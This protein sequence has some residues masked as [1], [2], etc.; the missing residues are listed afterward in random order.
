M[1]W[2]HEMIMEH[3]KYFKGIRRILDFC[4]VTCL[5]ILE[6]WNLCRGLREIIRNAILDL[7]I[8]VGNFKRERDI[9]YFST[10]FL[11]RW[12]FRRRRTSP[13]PV[14]FS[15]PF[16]IKFLNIIHHN[17]F[18]SSKDGLTGWGKKFSSSFFP[19]DRRRKLRQKFADEE[20]RK[21][22]R[23]DFFFFRK[24]YGLLNYFSLSSSF[25]SYQH[26]R[27]NGLIKNPWSLL[28]RSKQN[29]IYQLTVLAS[30][31]RFNRSET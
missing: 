25:F 22:G 17:E 19:P 28:F 10:T 8:S 12:M 23:K 21:E 6:K 3:R 16:R 11:T 27:L 14:S 26:D 15:P 18:S 5:S 31:Q 20:E 7:L 24:E 9:K 1:R 29:T 4:V 2:H 13:P 30:N